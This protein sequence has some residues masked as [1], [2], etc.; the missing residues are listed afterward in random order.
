MMDVP[1]FVGGELAGVVCHEH[2]GGVR[3]WAPDEVQFAVSIGQMLSLAIESELRRRAEEVLRQA[4]LHDALTGLPNRVALFDTL[5]RELG[6]MERDAAYG[7][8]VLYLDLDGFKPIND[9][10]GHE[11][12]DKLLASVAER[13]RRCLRPMDAAARMGGDEFV[14]VITDCRDASEAGAVA[15]RIKAA[16]SAPHDIDGRGVTVG[17][18]IGFAIAGG[19]SRDPSALL[20]AADDAMFHAKR[21][22]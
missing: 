18:S 11:I 2:V 3:A 17:V 1:V 10:F 9:T 20:R 13:L 8:A 6:R 15:A 7:F 14:A 22:R 5:H 19:A 16:L 4:A 21:H 12:G